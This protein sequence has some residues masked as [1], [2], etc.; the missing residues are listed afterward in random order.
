MYSG[1]D[2]SIS[3]NA[4]IIVANALMLLWYRLSIGSVNIVIIVIGAEVISRAKL[5]ICYT[6]NVIFLSP[7]MKMSK[8]S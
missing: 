1:L 8:I 6:C 4:I 5:Y 7:I 3:F 2:C